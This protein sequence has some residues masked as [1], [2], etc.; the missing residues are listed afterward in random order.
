MDRGEG[1]RKGREINKERKGR[2]KG[3]LSALKP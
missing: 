1:E 2:G 3:L